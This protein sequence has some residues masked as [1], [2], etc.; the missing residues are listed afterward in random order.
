MIKAIDMTSRDLVANPLMTVIDIRPWDERHGTEIGY[1][2][3]SISIPLDPVNLDLD[4]HHALFERASIVLVCLSGR[5]SAEVCAAFGMRLGVPVAHLAGGMLEWKAE[6]LP[7]CGIGRQPLRPVPA[8]TSLESVPRMVASCFVGELV[9]VALDQSDEDDDDVDFMRVLRRC[10]ELEGVA[11]DQPS[12]YG[13]MRVLDRAASVSRR[14][15]NDLGR[16]R[17]NLDSFT[18]ALQIFQTQQAAV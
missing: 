8:I 11:W 4:T 1:I 3:G 5:R 17:E 16:I 12:A 10:F 18:Q 13:L 7:T 2:P 15:G 14:F 6:G 9:E